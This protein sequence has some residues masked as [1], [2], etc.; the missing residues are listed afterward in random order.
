MIYWGVFIDPALFTKNVELD[1]GGSN[2][3]HKVICLVVL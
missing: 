3:F 1:L 2:K